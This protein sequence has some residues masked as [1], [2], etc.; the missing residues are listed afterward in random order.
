MYVGGHSD[1]PKT[2]SMGVH[3]KVS[4]IVIAFSVECDGIIDF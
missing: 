3:S 2:R 1:L 4:I